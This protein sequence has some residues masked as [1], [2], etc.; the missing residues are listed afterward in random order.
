LKSL[1]LF[2]YMGLAGCA[3]IPVNFDKTITYADVRAD[4]IAA[5]GIGCENRY[6]LEAPS[7]RDD[8]RPFKAG[9]KV[10]VR[11]RTVDEAYFLVQPALTFS[12]YWVP[13]SMLTL[14]PKS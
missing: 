5:D 11:G 8:C 3:H 4:M 13:A 1:V 2:L 7:D 6:A 9:E 14:R 10:S 12:H